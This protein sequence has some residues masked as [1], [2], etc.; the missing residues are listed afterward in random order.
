MNIWLFTG[1]VAVIAGATYIRRMK[2]IVKEKIEMPPL[3]RH[4]YINGDPVIVSHYPEPRLNRKM[5]IRSVSLPSVS[6]S[7]S[8]PM[9]WTSRL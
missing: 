5:E 8:S 9:I 1:V 2:N 3:K 7:R 6:K 4:T